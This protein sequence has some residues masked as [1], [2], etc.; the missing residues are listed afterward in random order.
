[1]VDTA[2]CLW[3][4]VRLLIV[5]CVEASTGRL[6]C[7]LVVWLRPRRFTGIDPRLLYSAA[8][9]HQYFGITITLG[10]A[11]GRP[12]LAAADTSRPRRRLQCSGCCC[13][14]A[15]PGH[16]ALPSAYP[17]KPGP[18][19]LPV[20]QLSCQSAAVAVPCGRVL[21]VLPLNGLLTG[22][23]RRFLARSASVVA[24]GR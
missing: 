1:M 12:C 22:V 13:C 24:A 2:W 18:A 6:G 7:W 15:R 11:G 23:R 5:F 21:S 3:T 17:A 9:L 14:V 19:S 20:S 4:A 10:L 8:V 16:P